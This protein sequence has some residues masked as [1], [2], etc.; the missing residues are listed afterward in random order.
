MVVP[1]DS[2]SDRALWSQ[3]HISDEPEPDEAEAEL[4]WLPCGIR[5]ILIA[6]GATNPQNNTTTMHQA[7]ATP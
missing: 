3:P 1:S 6:V 5:A 7:L 2:V 4:L